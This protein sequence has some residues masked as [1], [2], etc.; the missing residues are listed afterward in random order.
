MR[1]C[2]SRRCM[3][4]TANAFIDFGYCWAVFF[5]LCSGWCNF[6]NTIDGVLWWCLLLLKFIA[7]SPK[8]IVSVFTTS[9]V[10]LTQV[11]TSAQTSFCN[12]LIFMETFESFL[13]CPQSEHKAFSLF[14]RKKFFLVGNQKEEKVRWFVVALGHVLLGGL[15]RTCFCRE[16]KAFWKISTTIRD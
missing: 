15:S 2:R 10:N 7:A 16:L 4:D 3:L 12:E 14:L 9:T 11:A 13:W 8:F 6:L 5:A 1:I